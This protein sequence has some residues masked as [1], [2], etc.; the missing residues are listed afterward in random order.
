[1][2]DERTVKNWRKIKKKSKT[3]ILT[4][5]VSLI[6]YSFKL[7]FHL[8]SCEKFIT[9]PYSSIIVG[10]FMYWYIILIEYIYSKFFSQIIAIALNIMTR[11]S[12]NMI[13]KE[14][15]KKITKRNWA[16]IYGLR[17][18]LLD[19]KK[20]THTILHTLL[21]YQVL[22]FKWKFTFLPIVHRIEGIHIR[23]D[24]EREG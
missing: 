5:L 7:F 4:V 19:S 9:W 11:C 23:K 13:V 15:N 16:S 1:M 20:C 12:N 17:F 14:I 8:S 6:F 21:H 2:F 18:K 10:I 24:V 22:S 3:Y